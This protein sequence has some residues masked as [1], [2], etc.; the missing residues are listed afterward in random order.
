MSGK[1]TRT[2]KSDPL[3]TPHPDQKLSDDVTGVKAFHNPLE[4]PPPLDTFSML[5]PDHVRVSLTTSPSRLVLG[6]RLFEDEP[7]VFD[8][9]APLASDAHS[10]I[11]NV[12]WSEN[13]IDKGDN[14]YHFC[15][16]CGN[17]L[18][19]GREL[20]SLPVTKKEG[21]GILFIKFC[22]YKEE[23]AEQTAENL[24]RFEEI[25]FESTSSFGGYAK[26]LG[27][28]ALIVL[29][30]FSETTPSHF[31]PSQ[32]LQQNALHIISLWK[33]IQGKVNDW[34]NQFPERKKSFSL[35]GGAHQGDLVA[36]VLGVAGDKNYDVL[37][38]EVNFTAR[39]LGATDN[40][41]VLFVSRPLHEALVDGGFY[42]TTYEALVPLKG[43][44]GKHDIYRVTDDTPDDS[45]Y[46]I[47]II[48]KTLELDLSTCAGHHQ[49]T[50]PHCPYCGNPSSATSQSKE[51]AP[52]NRDVFVL[53]IDMVGFSTITT[54]LEASEI[55]RWVD[56]FYRLAEPIMVRHHGTIIRRAGD[57]I[58]VRFG[59][60]TTE[61]DAIN[62]VLAATRL[63][64]ALSQWNSQTDRSAIHVRMGI[65]FDMA[66][67]HGKRTVGTVVEKSQEKQSSAPH[68]GIL[69]DSSIA[70]RVRDY[71][72]LQKVSGGFEV[73]D[74]NHRAIELAKL[75]FQEIPF[76]GFELQASALNRAFSKAQKGTKQ[77]VLLKGEAG[78]GRHAVIANFYSEQASHV[79]ILTGSISD[80]QRDPLQSA[81]RKQ[82]EET[83]GDES[84]TKNRLDLFIRMSNLNRAVSKVGLPIGFGSPEIFLRSILG[85]YIGVEVPDS[86]GMT[87]LRQN[88][89]QLRLLTQRIV[90]LYLKSLT[91]QKPVIL[92]LHRLNEVDADTLIFMEGIFKEINDSPILIILTSTA[93]LRDKK[94]I[95]SDRY[96][97]IVFGNIQ[98]EDV[99][100]FI[101]S[102]LIKEHID[103]VKA[104]NEGVP[105]E[106][107]QSVSPEILK[108]LY[109]QSAGNPLFLATLVRSYYQTGWIFWD[110]SKESWELKLPDDRKLLPKTL[111]QA[112]LMRLDTLSP[113]E[114]SV[115]AAASVLA[116]QDG[117]FWL[118]PLLDLVGK[119]LRM[120]R[121][122][123]FEW[124]NESELDAILAGLEKKGLIALQASSQL[125]GMTEYRF[126]PPL[127]GQVN[128]TT[129]PL[130]HKKSMH[131]LFYQWFKKQKPEES[132]DS[133]DFLRIQASH[134]WG[135]GLLDEAFFLYFEAMKLAF[136]N[137]ANSQA[138]YYARLAKQALLL[139]QPNNLNHH[140]LQILL[141][142]SVI[143][144]RTASMEWSQIL[145]KM[146]ELLEHDKTL[147]DEL[148]LDVLIQRGSYKIQF[149]KNDP[150]G[151]RR[152]EEEWKSRI[153]QLPPEKAA[154]FYYGVARSFSFAN[155]YDEALQFYQTAADYSDKSGLPKIF[156][157]ILLGLSTVLG[158]L[159]RNQESIEK[160]EQ[161]ATLLEEL[162]DYDNYCFCLI[163]M[164]ASLMNLEHYAEAYPL[165]QK[166]SKVAKQIE[167]RRAEGYALINTAVAMAYLKGNTQGSL[168]KLDE[169]LRI[170]EIPREVETVA[171]FIRSFFVSRMNPNEGIILAQRAME[172]EKIPPL[173]RATILFALALAYARLEKF[174]E[175]MN[176]M[177]EALT[178][179]KQLEGHPISAFDNEFK[180]FAILLCD[181]LRN[182]GL[183][184][185]DY[186]KLISH[187]VFEPTHQP[188][189]LLDDI[190]EKQAALKGRAESPV[191]F[192]S[193]VK[194]E[195]PLAKEA[196]GKGSPQRPTSGRRD[197]RK[198]EPSAVN[199]GEEK[200]GLHSR[201]IYL[202]SPGNFSDEP[203][204]IRGGAELIM[205]DG[206]TALELLS[207]EENELDEDSE[208]ESDVQDLQDSQGLQN[209]PS[210]REIQGGRY[211]GLTT[212]SNQ[213]GLLLRKPTYLN[214]VK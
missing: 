132:A 196:V 182:K 16:Q 10:V 137:Y 141:T 155:R 127:W 189:P 57:E 152:N 24:D 162:G 126:I 80:W 47:P 183:L 144:E 100:S 15:N 81:L 197:G 201:I 165:L 142:E 14:D 7:T 77:I 166:A 60:P 46:Q 71:F 122:I 164:G 118:E 163:N 161:A 76:I 125:L 99:S 97:E 29:G 104:Q 157:K 199:D 119:N 92:E 40:R 106:M 121:P 34:N 186:E 39:I 168:E 86:P 25:V 173:F 90:A 124:E 4:L 115:M 108:Q 69:I 48:D 174:S 73:G 204:I 154:L 200:L 26:M 138:L 136:E 120:I 42:E 93:S 56:D 190:Y 129:V 203:D 105:L 145:D 89:A 65:Q 59:F 12:C 30:T 28:K 130:S 19:L 109:E 91:S 212:L 102:I 123:F 6:P 206:N 187:I 33:I 185:D 180:E 188:S 116:G 68:D 151:Q 85:R 23:D 98:P 58:L 139:W 211:N 209:I 49:I 172:H 101:T 208:I 78:S 62:A 44:R 13:R 160:A 3:P 96:D 146:E 54:D 117:Q 170:K 133:H 207:E 198:G 177:I 213:T 36:G 67:V 140:L 194:K 64:E 45:I 95:P 66:L 88:P 153:D 192:N 38:S 103:P 1:V 35:V 175:A 179:Q 156:A 171:C 37:G 87:Y 214:L 17:S 147:D 61:S 202:G 2:G 43:F 9:Q 50:T 32:K 11:C 72:A 167:N 70:E 22:D 135:A 112:M 205:T 74:A 150:E 94:E 27:D 63:R 113:I 75:K 191:S 178:I 8:E 111:D 169:A 52:Q 128:Y 107:G 55:F 20:S 159:N 79:T 195:G 193:P 184:T 84:S 21:V 82:F 41:E 158:R 134:A 181:F 51:T 148:R 176:L 31:N 114:R 131:S 53:S 143:C 18:R 149:E 210:L 83:P 110:S 5:P